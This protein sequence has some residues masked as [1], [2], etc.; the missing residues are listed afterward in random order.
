MIEDINEDVDE[1]QGKMDQALGGIQKL[2]K[3]KDNKLLCT[4]VILILVIVG[5]FIAVLS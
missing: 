1:V 4:I 2:L 5:L 3:T